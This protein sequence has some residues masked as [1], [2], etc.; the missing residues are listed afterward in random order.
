VK[1]PYRPDQQPTIVITH[2]NHDEVFVR[3]RKPTRRDQVEM[4]REFRDYQTPARDEEGAILK[5][6]TGAVI[7][8]TRTPKDYATKGLQRIITEVG[9][10][11]GEDGKPLPLAEAIDELLSEWLDVKEDGKPDQAFSRYISERVADPASWDNDP[12]TNG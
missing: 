6:E 5:D 3:A 9:G 12:K 2:P 1:R 7:F 4:F 10:I 8:V 11:E